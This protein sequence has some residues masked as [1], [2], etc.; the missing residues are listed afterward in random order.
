MNLTSYY[1]NIGLELMYK[2]EKYLPNINV[3]FLLNSSLCIESDLVEGK[4]KTSFH[5]C[6]NFLLLT[7][8]SS[9]PLMHRFSAT[10]TG[11]TPPCFA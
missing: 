8:S 2:K 5:T 7:L 3:R 1:V 4:N 6:I 9:F 10:V 11:A